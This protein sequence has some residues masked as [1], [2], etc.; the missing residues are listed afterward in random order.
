L[1]KANYLNFLLFLSITGCFFNLKNAFGQQKSENSILLYVETTTIALNEPLILHISFP[2]TFK[3]EYKSAQTIIFPDIPDMEKGNTV[4]EDD[5]ELKISQ[6]YWPRKSGTYITPKISF[7]IRDYEVSLR[8]TTV[9]VKTTKSNFSVEKQA[10]DL[11]WEESVP[12]LE[13]LWLYPK[14]ATY[15]R[16]QFELELSLLVPVDNREEWNFIDIK[17]Q[18][19]DLTKKIGSTGL[20]IQSYSNSE[21]PID[22]FEKDHIKFYKYT[23]YKA[24]AISVD[25]NLLK[26][27]PLT[28][29]YLTYK[30]Q[31]VSTGLFNSL[32]LINRV[33][34]TKELSTRNTTLNF[35]SLPPHPLKNDVAVGTFSVQTNK[36]KYKQRTTGFNFNFDITGNKY[37]LPLHQPWATQA[38]PGL[39]IH[40]KNQTTTEVDKNYQKT[41]FN[42]FIYSDSPKS[43]NIKNSLQWIYFN[44]NLHQYD[45]LL[46]NQ[47]VDMKTS[48]DEDQGANSEDSF[49]QMMYKASNTPDSLEKDESL[50]RFVN[51]III[52]LF[53]AISVLIFKR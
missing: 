27:P 4:Y 48:V 36:I 38:I 47:E 11:P 3:K 30:T 8:K 41:S 14:N 26:L 44:P 35:K 40:L 49:E 25:T 2:S 20:L 39:H 29:H 13:L 24:E 22:S 19:Q 46:V 52:I 7:N 16:Q 18:I 37:P 1:K 50:N 9:V 43:I 32:A 12:D 34:I 6:W 21:I 53:L 33:A 31:R 17:E 28:F 42:Y 51:L 5:K 23:I 10:F 15:E 45:T